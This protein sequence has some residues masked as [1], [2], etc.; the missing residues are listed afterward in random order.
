M[1][2]SDSWHCNNLTRKTLLLTLLIANLLFQLSQV[3]GQ[4]VNT[5]VTKTTV[6]NTTVANTTVVAIPAVST[7]FPTG[8]CI[9]DCFQNSSL[10]AGYYYCSTSFTMGACCAPNSTDPTCLDNP[11]LGIQCSQNFTLSN[12]SAMYAFCPRKS[13]SCG[14]GGSIL[15]PLLNLNQTE[16][17]HTTGTKPTFM[18]QTLGDVCYWELYLDPVAFQASHLYAQNLLTQVYIN[19]AFDVLPSN[20]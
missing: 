7:W 11:S 8:N 19:I 20:T 1:R 10:S 3:S 17:L 15:R 6:A 4:V 9:A 2:I 13:S 14:G 12:P 5:T 18:N 16:W